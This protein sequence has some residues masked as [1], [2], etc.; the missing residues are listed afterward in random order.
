V[1]ERGI[2]A[3]ALVGDWFPDKTTTPAIL[4]SPKQSC[5]LSDS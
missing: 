5:S 4:I 1:S 2:L 3:A